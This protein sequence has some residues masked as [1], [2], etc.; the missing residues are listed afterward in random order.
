MTWIYFEIFKTYFTLIH[1][2]GALC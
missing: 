2:V 1:T